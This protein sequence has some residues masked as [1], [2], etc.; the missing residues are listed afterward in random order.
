MK[1]V[2]IFL[3][4]LSLMLPL[5]VSCGDTESPT[6]ETTAET[7]N[8]GKKSAVFTPDKLEPTTEQ[9]RDAVY[10][11]M[12]EM[13]QVKWKTPETID[14]SEKIHPKLIFQKNVEY[15]G[16]P[17]TYTNKNLEV[18]LSKLEDGIYLGPY[19]DSGAIGN[20]CSSSIVS[21]YQQISPDIK[22]TNTVTML[23]LSGKGGLKVGDYVINADDTCAED[24]VK[25][26]EAEVIYDSYSKLQK[27]DYVVSAAGS[28]GNTGHA[29]M[30]VEVKITT[31]GN[32]KI[33]PHRSTV[34][35]I[36]QT[37]S[38]D[39]DSKLKTT[40][41]V[42]HEY[43]F[44]ALYE[45]SYLPC[46]I[47]ELIEE[48]APLEVTLDGLNT[49]KTI[50]GGSLRGTVK[51]NYMIRSFTLKVTNESGEDVVNETYLNWS[52]NFGFAGKETPEE[53]STLPAGKYTCRMI[54]DTV[55]GQAAVNGFD[56]TV[57]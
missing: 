1:K 35:T 12:Y 26:N 2:L 48:P 32:G 11:Y 50:T 44:T 57:K 24:V 4:S 10:N 21:A 7:Q 41:W 53:L 22:L 16:V 51:A 49:A 8:G 29:R 31:A 13:S 34:K 6:A 40:W 42:H 54:I 19:T 43:T 3:L 23:P 36:E 33:N 46:T 15:T 45:K 14:L 5:F 20:T 52:Q 37:N 47:K 18:F 28:W 55:I 39:P 38:F 9:L 56:F 17:Y 27:G 30:V 25:H